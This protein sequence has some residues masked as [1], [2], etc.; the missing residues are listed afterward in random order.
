MQN[1]IGV[2]EAL[3]LHELMKFK[4]LCLTKATVM[5]GLVSDNELKDI[6]KEDVGASKRHLADLKIYVKEGS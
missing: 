4:S 5:Q 2:H 6:M 1:N 3:E